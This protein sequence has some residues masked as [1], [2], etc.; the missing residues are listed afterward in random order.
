MQSCFLQT[1]KKKRINTAKLFALSLRFVRSMKEIN[2]NLRQDISFWSELSEI[3]LV[4]PKWR[5]Y[6]TNPALKLSP[7][8][9]H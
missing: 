5:K 2:F 7:S 9:P 3:T 8:G 4:G 6:P 1:I